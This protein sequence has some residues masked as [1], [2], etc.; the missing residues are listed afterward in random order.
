MP[1]LSMNAAVLQ[2]ETP[3]CLPDAAYHTAFHVFSTCNPAKSECVSGCLLVQS[4]EIEWRFRPLH[5]SIWRNRSAFSTV[6]LLKAAKSDGVSDLCFLQCGEWEMKNGG[7]CVQ[8]TVF[9]AGKLGN[10]IAMRA[11]R[12]VFRLFSGLFDD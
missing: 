10:V 6:Y 3:A 9:A 7:N 8:I 1:I 4:G 11:F 5:C 12:S 2:M